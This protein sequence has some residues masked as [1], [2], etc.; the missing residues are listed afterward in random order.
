MRKYKFEFAK[1]Q[2]GTACIRADTEEEADRLMNDC[3][4]GCLEEDEERQVEIE[5]DGADFDF[6]LVKSC[7]DS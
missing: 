2:Y 5:Y 4:V 3:L 1:H 7:R 6:D